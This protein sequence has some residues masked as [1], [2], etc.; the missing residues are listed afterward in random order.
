MS[1]KTWEEEFYPVEADSPEAQA[2]TLAAV[3]HSLRK[4]RGLRPEALLKHRVALEGPYHKE[5]VDCG[6]ES[7]AINVS[8]C[9]LCLKFHCCDGCPLVEVSGLTC[10]DKGS[11]WNA[12]IG[13][14]EPEPMIA[15]LEQALA[16]VSGHEVDVTDIPEFDS[17]LFA[18]AILNKPGENLSSTVRAAREKPTHKDVVSIPVDYNNTRIDA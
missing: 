13:Q 2:S 9:A 8:S 11:A 18:D 5:V 6:R 15:Q 14:A 4:W 10:G 7:L 3:K 12:Y 16:L 17:K 1:L